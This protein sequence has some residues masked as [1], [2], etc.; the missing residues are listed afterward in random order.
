MPAWQKGQ[1]GNPAGRPKNTPMITP[2]IRHY[3]AM[4]IIEIMG[5][6]ERRLELPAADAIA[7][8][9]VYKAVND[10]TYGDSTRSELLNRVDGPVGKDDDEAAE[11]VLVRELIIQEYRPRSIESDLE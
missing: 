7:I 6:Y 9:Y 8:V 11:R 10:I 4:S 5:L 3:L 1:S 2:K